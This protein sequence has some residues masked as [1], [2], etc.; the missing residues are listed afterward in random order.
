MGEEKRK[1]GT[2]STKVGALD[3][4]EATRELWVLREFRH[5]RTKGFSLDG[6]FHKVHKISMGRENK[7]VVLVGINRENAKSGIQGHLH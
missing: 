4:Q 1:V 2:P 3:S 6:R 7:N 5:Y